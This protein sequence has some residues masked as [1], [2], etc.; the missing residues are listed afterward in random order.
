MTKVYPLYATKDQPH[1]HNLI[2][3]VWNQLCSTRPFNFV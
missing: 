3:M 2:Q 1:P